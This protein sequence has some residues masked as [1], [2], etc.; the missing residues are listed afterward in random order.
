MITDAHNTRYCSPIGR[1][2]APARIPI[3]RLYEVSHHGQGGGVN[4]QQHSH[5]QTMFPW[6]NSPS[7][8]PPSLFL[9]CVTRTSLCAT[10]IHVRDRRG[11]EDR[12]DW[13][14]RQRNQS[15]SILV[16]PGQSLPMSPT[17]ET[18]PPLLI[19]RAARC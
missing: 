12:C 9:L 1:S 18:V 17:D 19:E 4:L 7:Y 11:L 13:L 6:R 8:I 2:T 3:V 10:S 16:V 15:N 14:R 5:R